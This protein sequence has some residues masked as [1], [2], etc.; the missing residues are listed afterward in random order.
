MS[1]SIDCQR[2]NYIL[3]CIVPVLRAKIL[4]NDQIWSMD[5]VDTGNKM[6][7][8]VFLKNLPIKVKV[9]SN[10]CIHVEIMCVGITKICIMKKDISCNSLNIDDSV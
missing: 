4:D 8:I 2:Q 3:D 6:Q 1:R 10:L 5:I 9:K 7:N